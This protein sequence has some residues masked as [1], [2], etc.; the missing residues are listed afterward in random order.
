M[1]AA[2]LLPP[3][4]NSRGPFSSFLAGG[5]NGDRQSRPAG[6][7]F[8]LCRPVSRPFAEG[9]RGV[10]GAVLWGVERNEVLAGRNY[11]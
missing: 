2:G 9:G 10:R 4:E 8:F 7:R 3:P 6:A 1:Y 11:R 5:E